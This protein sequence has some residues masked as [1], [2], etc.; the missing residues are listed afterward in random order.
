VESKQR[1][2][3]ENPQTSPTLLG[4]LRESPTDGAAWEQFVARDGPPTFVWCRSKGLQQADAKDVTQEILVGMARSFAKFQ[5]DPAKSFR[6]WLRRVSSRALSEYIENAKHSLRGSGASTVLQLV[7]LAQARVAL[8]SR[9]EAEFDLELLEEAMA[10]VRLR[11]EP[12]TWEAFQA[13]AIDGQS[14]V[15]V[16]IR[17]SLNIAAVYNAKSRIQAM[18]REE[19]SALDRHDP[20]ELA[21]ECSA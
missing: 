10:R 15:D 1:N 6:R 19:L 12:A 4:R 8:A 16:A 5:C 20:P 2:S 21:D 7:H 18:I 9:F 13:T 14:G 3:E 11:V 17:L